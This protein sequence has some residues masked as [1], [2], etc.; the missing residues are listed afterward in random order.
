MK[1]CLKK[2]WEGCV[3]CLC[4]FPSS[5]K[6]IFFFKP[7]FSVSM[8][9]VWYYMILKTIIDRRKRIVER[10]VSF[11]FKLLFC[12]EL[13]KLWSSFDKWSS[14]NIIFFCGRGFWNKKS[15]LRFHRSLK[16]YQP[17]VSSVILVIKINCFASW[18]ELVWIL[19]SCCSSTGAAGD[20]KAGVKMEEDG[21]DGGGP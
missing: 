9:V 21:R 2:T 6:K 20:Q 4:F 7:M 11:S 17:I 3:C 1:L 15:T 18:D 12:N 10:A 13:F 16:A 5:S 8:L 14:L 19:Y